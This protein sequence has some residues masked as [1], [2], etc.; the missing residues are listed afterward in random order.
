MNR[1][2]VAVNHLSRRGTPGVGTTEEEV[3]ES[4]RIGEERKLAG[5]REAAEEEARELAR[6]AA[7]APKTEEEDR[8]SEYKRAAEGSNPEDGRKAEEEKARAGT[9]VDEKKGPVE[10]DRVRE[11]PRAEEVNNAAEGE[12]QTSDEREDEEQARG[13]VEELLDQM[14][15]RQPDPIDGKA[16]QSSLLGEEDEQ[17][18]GMSSENRPFIEV[19]L[20][21]V[22]YRALFDSGAMI[23]LAGPKVT[24]RYAARLQKGKTTV[25]SVTGGLNKVLGVLEVS[26]EI[27]GKL[28][29]LV[30]KAVAGIDHDMIL[31][32]DF[33]NKFDIC[34]K[35]A[36]RLWRAGDVEWMSFAGQT[37]G[38]AKLV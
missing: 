21:G 24:E 29:K 33:I 2:G 34:A 25:K 14:G 1:D 30:L 7:A 28:A 18:A 9:T 38:P 37:E 6:A 23:S 12:M 11:Q 27:G 19:V 35:L 5:E 22:T 4:Q 20:G 3:K 10:E 13:A 31:G 15:W 26:I 36:K 16:D 17:V 8:A 32:M